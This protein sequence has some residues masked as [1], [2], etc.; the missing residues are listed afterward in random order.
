[1]T[2]KNYRQAGDEKQ[3][4]QPV[5]NVPPVIIALIAS[6]VAVHLLRLAVSPDIDDWIVLNF[7]FT[8]ARFVT[9]AQLQGMVFPGGAGANVWT[10]FTHMF[11]HGDW[12]HLLLNSLWML[13]FGVVVARRF[14]AARFLLFS[15]VAAAFGALAN[16][17]VYWGQ[18]GLM[19]G[20]SGAI[21][22]QMAGALRLMFS[23]PAG[24]ASFRSDQLACVHVVPLRQLLFNRSAVLFVGVWILVN[25]LVAF[26]GFGTG[27]NIGRIAWEAHLGGFMAGL[28]L[29]GWFDP[30]PRRRER[31]Y[32]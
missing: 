12:A 18:F 19:I 30:K 10:F 4:H 24:L 11:L 21:S 17:I 15:L 8:A 26:S 6:F 1:M 23:V 13:A 20:A 2:E 31:L 27:D 22:G 14:G 28:L 7:A 16:L 29:F 25:F 9:P 5:F 32:L 3:E